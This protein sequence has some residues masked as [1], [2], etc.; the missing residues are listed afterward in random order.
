MQVQR[1]CS[2]L[3]LRECADSGKEVFV[4]HRRA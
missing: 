3:G 4:S 2:V 1:T